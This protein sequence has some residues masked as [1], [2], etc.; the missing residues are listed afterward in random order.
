MDDNVQQQ[1]QI[2][3]LFSD[4]EKMTELPTKYKC[5]ESLFPMHK[6]SEFIH[7]FKE[8][9]PGLLLPLNYYF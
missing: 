5:N 3:E 4:I 6:L 7:V 1:G 2:K 8:L 9:D